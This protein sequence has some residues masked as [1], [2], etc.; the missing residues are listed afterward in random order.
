[1]QVV[2]GSVHEPNVHF[3]APPSPRVPMEMSR[4]LKWFHGTAPGRESPLPILTRTGIAHLYFV[5]I[6][7][8]EDGN[9]RIGRAI[10]LKA[11]SEALG[12][13]I[14]IAL[15]HTINARRNAYYESLAGAREHH[16][17]NHRLAYLVRP[18]RFG[19]SRPLAATGLVSHRK[20]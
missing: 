8:F 15:S 1:M 10:A 3:E 12:Q 5:S 7:P 4:F 14:L 6:H 2:S 18:N 9:G 16:S 11:V 17:R 13:P 19:S 20:N